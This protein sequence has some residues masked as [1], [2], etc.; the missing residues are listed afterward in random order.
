[1]T[2]YNEYNLHSVGGNMNSNRTLNKL[3]YDYKTYDNYLKNMK[4]YIKKGQIDI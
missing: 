4:F 3:E 1:M 2:Q